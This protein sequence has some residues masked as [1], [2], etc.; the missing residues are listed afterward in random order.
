MSKI[1][2]RTLFKSKIHRA[3]VTHADV[4]YEG[5]VTVDADLLDAADILPHEEVH[6]WNVTRGSRL[7][8]YALPG[9]RGSGVVCVNGAAAHLCR[10]GDLVIIATFAQVAE[11]DARQHWPT[12]VLVD[13]QNRIKQFRLQE[14]PG[15]RRRD[16]ASA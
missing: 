12:V 10:P 3:T 4:D 6:I 11:A 1:L 9:D 13:E 16:N 8:T 2:G 5:S 15:P 14:I 7:T